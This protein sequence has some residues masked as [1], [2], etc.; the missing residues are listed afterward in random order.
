MVLWSMS[1]SAKGLHVNIVSKNRNDNFLAFLD[2]LAALNQLKDASFKI[3]EKIQ[4][5]TLSNWEI[6]WNFDVAA[7][8]SNKSV[9]HHVNKPM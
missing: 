2:I 3:R 7:I 9:H 5:K 1:F 8:T 4:N 6:F